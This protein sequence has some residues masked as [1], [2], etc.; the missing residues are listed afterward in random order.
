VQESDIQYEAGRV[1]LAASYTSGRKGGR[2]IEIPV[3]SQVLADRKRSRKAVSEDARWSTGRSAIGKHCVNLQLDFN[4]Y[5]YHIIYANSNKTVTWAGT[6]KFIIQDLAAFRKQCRAIHLKRKNN[7]S[8]C[9]GKHHAMKKCVR[10]EIQLQGFLTL[11]LYGSEWLDSCSDSFN[12]TEKTPRYLLDS[13]LGGSQNRTGSGDE[14]KNT[15]RAG[16]RTPVAQRE[17]SHYKDGVT[18]A[19]PSYL[20]LIINKFVKS[21]SSHK[22]YTRRIFTP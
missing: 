22:N 16:N 11:A 3:G 19:H 2:S 12:S 8:L 7:A 6:L 4:I 20:L 5:V 9:S 18:V 13:S 14:N 21:D 15:S 1:G 10:M 17:V